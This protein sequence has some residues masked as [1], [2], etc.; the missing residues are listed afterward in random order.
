MGII[1]DLLKYIHVNKDPNIVAK[2]G[3]KH[4]RER[5]KKYFHEIGR[6]LISFKITAATMVHGRTLLNSGVCG[7][8]MYRRS[9]MVSTNVS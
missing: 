4:I 3:K 2:K 9:I 7:W 1:L 5:V 8:P 6:S